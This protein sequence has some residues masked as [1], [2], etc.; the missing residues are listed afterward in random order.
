MC[1]HLYLSVC[2]RVVCDEDN[3]GFCVCVCVCVCVDSLIWFSSRFQMM[4]TT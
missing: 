3:N 2:L 4:I 1:M